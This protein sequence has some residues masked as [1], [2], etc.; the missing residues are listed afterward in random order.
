VAT[1]SAGLCL[2]RVVIALILAV[3]ETIAVG[4]DGIVDLATS[5]ATASITDANL[6]ALDVGDTFTTGAAVGIDETSVLGDHINGGG[7]IQGL[8]EGD[9]PATDGRVLLE[10]AP[11]QKGN[12]SG[13]VD[14]EVTGKHQLRVV[15]R[16]V[17]DIEVTL[18]GVGNLGPVDS[19]TGQ[20]SGGV[21]GGGRSTGIAVG[22]GQVA[23]VVGDVDVEEEERVASHQVKTGSIAA[24]NNQSGVKRFLQV[25]GGSGALG[26]STAKDGQEEGNKVH[27][28]VKEDKIKRDREW[29][30]VSI[31]Y[32]KRQVCELFLWVS[33]L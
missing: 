12:V 19:I 7:H 27:W 1:T 11:T 17:R 15:I 21:Q 25:A 29:S 33:H 30:R 20:G 18:R 10:D 2:E 5:T 22:E 14:G 9:E 31:G 24:G 4:I 16:E 23:I 13:R 26:P 28:V 6:V 3:A 32:R 8:W